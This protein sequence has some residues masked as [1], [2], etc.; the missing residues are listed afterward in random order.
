MDSIRVSEALDTGSLPAGRQ[1]FLEAENKLVGGENDN[2]VC[3]KEFGE[4]RNLCGHGH[5][6][7]RSIDRT[8]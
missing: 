7:G 4:W 5:A 2:C 1:G 8:Q 6:S 3:D